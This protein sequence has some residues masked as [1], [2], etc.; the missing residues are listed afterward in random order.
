MNPKEDLAMGATTGKLAAGLLCFA[1]LAGS[2][3]HGTGGESEKKP[4]PTRTGFFICEADGR[5]WIFRE[6]SKEL[7]E[8]KQTGEPEKSY[9]RVGVQPYKVTLRAPNVATMEEYLTAK[10]GFVTKYDD[11]RLWVFKKDCKEYVEFLKDGELAKHV[12]RPGAGPRRMTVKAPD[13]TTVLAYMAAQDGF[14]TVLDNGRLW[15]FL[16]NSKEQAEYEKTGE[17]TKHVERINA[18]PLG[19]TLRA[20]DDAILD[21]YL[22]ACAR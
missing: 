10:P 12:V 2:A 19:L 7:A 4:L 9:T 17:L 15:V 18:G 20:V 16:P 14:A 8:F 11:G 13:H 5:W 6:G 1:A 3:V 22:K 21:A